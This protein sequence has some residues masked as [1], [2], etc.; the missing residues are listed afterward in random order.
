MKKTLVLQ[1]RPEDETADAEFKAILEKGQI[2]PENVDRIRVEQL[3]I[4]DINLEKYNAII[5]GGSPFDISTPQEKK[6]E[7]QLGVESF[8]ERLFPKVI[9]NDFPFLG[10]CSGNGLLGKHC[11]VNISSKF[12]EPIGPV[13][14]T[15]TEAGQK[16]DLLVNF[17]RKFLALVGH[18]EACDEV[19]NGATLLVTSK[20]CPVQ[21]FRIKNNIYATQFHPEADEEQ[22]CIR[23]DIYKHFG[24]FNPDEE[25]RLKSLLKGVKTPE[26]NEI[27]KR[28]VKKY[29]TN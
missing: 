19:P 25:H 28:F 29:T 13:E 11:N 4:T 18:K 16:D 7:T 8:F 22:F 20:A 5:A 26:S 10:A 2:D 12:S 3:K 24:Y 14:V 17:P 1:M 21:M 27:L 23:I 15:I 6:S 9:S